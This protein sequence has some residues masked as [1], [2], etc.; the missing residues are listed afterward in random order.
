VI[1]RYIKLATVLSIF[2][3]CDASDLSSG[4]VPESKVESA[5]SGL[6][7]THSVAKP[8]L[9]LRMMSYGRSAACAVVCIVAAYQ[10]LTVL[11]SQTSDD[12][13][14]YNPANDNIPEKDRYELQWSMNQAW[15][16]GSSMVL[17]GGGGILFYQDDLQQ[18]PSSRFYS[19]IGIGIACIL[20]TIF[21][22][23]YSIKAYQNDDDALDLPINALNNCLPQKILI[24]G[25]SIAMLAH[26]YIQLRQAWQSY[27]APKKQPRMDSSGPT[28]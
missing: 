1:K 5:Q 17:S 13:Y 15:L 28:I 23:R 10:W 18:L 8:P 9:D 11:Q 22:A 6:S 16:Y 14:I 26:G 3:M 4:Y 20:G 21:G 19:R 7:Q 2:R 25:S 12:L 27:V 24:I